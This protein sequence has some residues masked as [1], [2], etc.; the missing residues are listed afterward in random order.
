MIMDKVIMME[1]NYNPTI[2]RKPHQ[3]FA[4]FLSSLL[5][6]LIFYDHTIHTILY[7]TI[8]HTIILQAFFL[9]IKKR[10]KA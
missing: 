3:H 10:L 5:S 4:L 2:Q 7:M 1:I 8:L 6:V 9:V